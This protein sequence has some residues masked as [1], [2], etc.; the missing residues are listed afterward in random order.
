MNE[1]LTLFLNNKT[2]TFVDWLHIVLK[3][4]KEVTVTN[5]GTWTTTKILNYVNFDVLLL[6][7]VY[8]KAIKRKTSTEDELKVKKEK[9]D[10]PKKPAEVKKEPRSLTDDLPININRMSESRKIVV[11]KDNSDGFDIP[12][13][14]EAKKLEE[15]EDRIKTVK[16][17][18]GGIVNS[19][20]DEESLQQKADKRKFSYLYQ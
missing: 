2:S 13:L 5:P 12:L 6:L 11:T 10:K 8:K 7:E 19:D 20:D 16:K 18:L 9:K 17:R 1:D 15:I 4:L 14:S 3:K